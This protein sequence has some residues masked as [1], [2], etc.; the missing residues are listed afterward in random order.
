M[1]TLTE[2]SLTALVNLLCYY[3]YYYF[4]PCI[5][6][7]KEFKYEREERNKTNL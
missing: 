3:Y 6:R 7:S 4:I 5:V 1:L 2:L